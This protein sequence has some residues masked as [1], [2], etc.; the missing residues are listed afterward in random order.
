MDEAPFLDKT[1]LYAVSIL[2][3]TSLSLSILVNS[4]KQQR[5]TTRA[6]QKYPSNLTGIHVN[7]T[8]TLFYPVN[9]FY[10]TLKTSDL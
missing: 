6:Q 10:Y 5:I 3:L 4:V 9:L 2:D 8:E 1:L 7:L